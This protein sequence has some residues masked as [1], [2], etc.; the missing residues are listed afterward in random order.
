MDLPSGFHVARSEPM[1][2]VLVDHMVALYGETKAQQVQPELE[3]LLARW[4]S[5]FAA[6]AR[7]PAATNATLP[8]TEKDAL[9][10]TCADQVSEIG[11]TPLQSLSAF[12]NRHLQGV[13]SGVHLLP[14]YPWSSDDGFSVKDYYAVDPALGSWAD[15]RRLGERFDLMFDAVFNHMSAQGGWFAKFVAG[16]PAYRDFFVT[17]EGDPDLSQVIRPRALPLLTGFETPSGRTKVWT[18]FSADQVDLNV[19]NPAVLLA[20]LDVLLFHVSQGARFIRLD[21]IAFLWKEI[22]TSCL[23]LPPT[24]RVVQLM[25][26]VLEQSAPPT[27]LI[28]ETNVPHVD[29]LSYFG[30]GRNEAHL[31]YNFA[32]P[33]LVLHTLASGDATKLT[34]WAHSLELPSASVA[35]FNFLASH[36]GIGLN[37]ARGIL[38]P[39]EIDALVART[40]ERGGFISYK[41]LPDRSQVPY[42]MNINFFDALSN[43]GGE[44][45]E[46]QI[47][48]MVCAHAIQLSLAGVPGIYFHSLFGSRGDRAGAEASGIP[49]RI[50]RQKL[51]RPSLEQE[52][53][54]PD[55]LRARIF[56]GL[57]ALLQA[58]RGS[59]A[60]HPCGRQDVITSDSQLFVL[61]RTS[62][63]ERE[64][65]LCVHNISGERVDAVVRCGEAAPS[66]RSNPAAEIL[67][68]ERNSI[69]SPAEDAFHVSL[70]AHSV[71]WARI[72]RE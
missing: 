65:V 52:L 70:A 19:R 56:S 57:R 20:L 53:A 13:V 50:N 29:N 17:V 10:I 34:R 23:N 28:T 4:R 72:R 12:S 7:P 69:L 39:A 6:S 37:P 1:N 61:W 54:T 44:P 64:R 30:D 62:P 24:H 21:A 15:I 35:L 55:S 46:T 3:A 58:R 25:R 18:T 36:D 48:R 2:G 60:F 71:M 63:D 66:P 38:D 26:R 40:L 43:P 59:A 33:P 16:D 11:Q 68:G 41:H 42:E 22:G 9:L 32:L 45:V 27:M 67:F 49:R 14:F 5:T 47:A 51:T 31:V 8:V